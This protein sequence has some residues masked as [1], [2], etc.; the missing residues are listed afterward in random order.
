MNGVLDALDSEKSSGA[1]LKQQLEKQ[2]EDLQSNHVSDEGCPHVST[3]LLQDI[4]ALSKSCKMI[5]SEVVDAQT[6]EYLANLGDR[7][8][9]LQGSVDVLTSKVQRQIE[10]LKYNTSRHSS[11]KR[12][13]YQGAYWQKTKVMQHLILGGERKEMAKCFAGD[14]LPI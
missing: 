13:Q 10:A 3:V 8:K 11:A 14:M 2:I 6:P 1:G 5:A 7:T 12:S 4:D 9:S